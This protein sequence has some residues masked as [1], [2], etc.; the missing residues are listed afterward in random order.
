MAIHKGVSQQFLIQNCQFESSDRVLIIMK[1]RYVVTIL[2][3]NIRHNCYPLTW[4][5]KTFKNTSI[6]SST[7]LSVHYFKSFGSFWHSSRR[8]STIWP[9][10]LIFF[11]QFFAHYLDLR[12]IRI[13]AKNVTIIFTPKMAIFIVFFLI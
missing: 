6:L 12:L 10:A 1:V 3:K 7:T 13:F 2:S 5:S 8:N 9:K 11:N 4:H